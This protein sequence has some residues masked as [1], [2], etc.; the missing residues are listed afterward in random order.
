MVSGYRMWNGE[1]AFFV[2]ESLRPF[3][4]HDVYYDAIALAY[5]P[6]TI[7]GVLSFYAYGGQANICV[8]DRMGHVVYTADHV[9]N[10]LDMLSRYDGPEKK[11]ASADMDERCA[12]CVTLKTTA[13]ES[14]Y[15]AYRPIEDTPYMV[16]CEAACSLVQNVL[17]DYSALIARIVAAALAILDE[18]DSG[19]DVDAVRTV[20]AGIRKY[21]EDCKGS[22]LIITHSTKILESL[23]VDA[24]HVM[25]EGSI[26]KNGG[27]SL[28][29]EINE[30]GFAEYEQR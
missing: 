1:E 9:W 29:D 20:S 16:V 4:V 27:A 8:V 2:V 21:Q 15:L 7:N 23:H 28:V 24:T 22:L 30:S 13:G 3:A 5:T 17:R 10:R 14:V 19:L 26:I 12:G 18:T 11:Q 25:V 6:G